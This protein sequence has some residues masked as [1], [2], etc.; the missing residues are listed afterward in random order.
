[1]KYYTTFA[2]NKST[3]F[4]K[5]LLKFLFLVLFFTVVFVL[6]FFVLS[7][8]QMLKDLNNK[9]VLSNFVFLGINSLWI[10]STI[11]YIAKKSDR[12][13][14]EIM[15]RLSFSLFFIY[16]FMPQM[17][18]L[19]FR[20]AFFVVDK[21]AILLLVVAAGVPVVLTVL[22]GVKL[23]RNNFKP[24]RYTRDQGYFTVREL[25]IKL[26]SAGLCYLAIYVVFNY[27][28]AWQIEDLRVFYTG[29]S[30]KAGFATHLVEIRN[31]TPSLYLFQFAKGVLFGLFILPVADM[32]KNK[33]AAMLIT[34]ILL[35][36]TS[37]LRPIIP[38]F[39]LPSV[40][41]AGH[42]LEM[43]SSLLLFSIIN[44]LLF[45]KLKTHNSSYKYY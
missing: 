11:L 18:T 40:V 34:L 12:T 15:L 39:L 19:L 44:W 43:S 38:D 28:V 13:N 26:L 14:R 41:R 17:E 5:T 21:T 29:S 35:L 23:F 22:L 1:M 16:A 4:M 3:G 27:F 9:I 31:A 25:T 7:Y 30:E 6:F 37:A 33:S 36:E 2:F 20:S 24:S 10:C 32:F 8:S 42:L 45:R